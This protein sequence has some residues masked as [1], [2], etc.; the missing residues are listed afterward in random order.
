MPNCPRRPYD[1]DSY[2]P[3]IS[4]SLAHK[5][6]WPLTSIVEQANAEPDDSCVVRVRDWDTLRIRR[7]PG[8]AHDAIGEIPPGACHVEPAGGCEGDWCRIVWRGHVG[9][10]NSFYLD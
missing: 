6:V 1:P 5:P 8:I 4:C 7:G 10:V 3:S 9:W 2:R